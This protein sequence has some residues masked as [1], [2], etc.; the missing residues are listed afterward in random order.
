M[1]GEEATGLVERD[2][3]RAS[4]ASTSSSTMPGSSTSARSRRSRPRNMKRS[5][6]STSRRP[7]TPSRAAFA[8]MKQNGFGRII[9][10]ASAHGL[11]ASP[12]KS[13]YVAAKHGVVGLTK[14]RR[15]RR[16][17]AWHH[18]QRDLPGLCLDAAGREP[19]RRHRQGARHHAAKRSSATCCSLPSPTSASPTSR[20][21]ARSPSSCAAPAAAR[22]PAPRCRSTAAG[23]RTEPD[24]HPTAINRPRVVIVGAGFGGLPRPSGSPASLST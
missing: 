10:V 18:L 3:R 9:N 2:D 7:G 4:A 16:R 6:R 14:T 17:R 8:A 13:A 11:V 12:F 24:M 22:S 1:K 21:L 5:S 23:R 15:A 19:D 20:S